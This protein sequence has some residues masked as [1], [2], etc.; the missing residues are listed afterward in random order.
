MLC[1]LGV[2]I[3]GAIAGSVI[4]LGVARH[5]IVRLANPQNW[6][7]LAMQQLTRKLD[8]RPDQVTQVN[9]IVANAVEDIRLG[10]RQRIAEVQ[11]TLQQSRANISAVL[12]AEQEKKFEKLVAER[13]ERWKGFIEMK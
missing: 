9:P 7:Q 6:Q 3:A 8:L 1:F 2:F 10:R 11:Q 4:T 13:Q 12:D 5:E